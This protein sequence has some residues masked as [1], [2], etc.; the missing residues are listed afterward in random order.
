MEQKEAV[1][2]A[3]FLQHFA[4]YARNGEQENPILLKFCLDMSN[5]HGGAAASI[6]LESSLAQHFSM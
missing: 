2:C 4:M 1:S 5:L 3:T 6:V